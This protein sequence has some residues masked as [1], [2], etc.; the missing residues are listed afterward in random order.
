MAVP[1]APK[2]PRSKLRSDPGDFRSGFRLAKHALDVNR[3]EKSFSTGEYFAFGIQDLAAVGVLAAFDG[4]GVALG[5]E[6]L[7]QG[8]GLQVVDLHGAGKGDDVAGLVDL[9][10]HLIQDG[11]YDAAVNVAWR[12]HK[13][14]VESETADVTVASLVVAETELHARVVVLAADETAIFL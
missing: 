9:T 6:R 10:H 14:V 4:D 2:P 12:A 3:D 1:P 13:A 7:V 8:D 11:G 5:A